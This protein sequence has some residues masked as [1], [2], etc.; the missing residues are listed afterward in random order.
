MKKDQYLEGGENMLKNADAVLSIT[1]R[2]QVEEL[3]LKIFQRRLDFKFRPDAPEDVKRKLIDSEPF[4]EYIEEA[5]K[6]LQDKQQRELRNK[7]Y[8]VIE[9][10]ADGKRGT[11]GGAYVLAFVYSKH[12]GNIVVKGYMREVEEYIKKNIKTHYFVNYSLW[13]MGSHRD[14]WKFWKDSVG[15]HEPQRS[16]KRRK[17]EPKHR[18]FRVR[19]YTDW[20]WD[21]GEEEYQQQQKQA[22]EQELVFKRMP[23]RWIPEFDKF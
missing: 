16:C 22:D 4:Q 9:V 7:K 17:I 19:P 21:V 6:Q 5:R 10:E 3:A 12:S 11:A 18:K 2:K 8:P 14:I 13:Y 23:K 20:K 1:N 15:V